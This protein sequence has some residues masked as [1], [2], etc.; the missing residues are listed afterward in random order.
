LTK[1]TLKLREL[2]QSD[3][4][5][6]APGVFNP[7]LAR[8]AERQG[9]SALYAGGSAISINVF[10]RPDL[11]LTSLSERVEAVYRMTEATQLPVIVDADIGFGDVL[12]LR[13]CVRQLERVGAAAIHI[14]DES[15][16]TSHEFGVTPATTA[17]MCKRI[18]IAAN[19][20]DDS[21]F[22]IFARC[23][24]LRT[25]GIHETVGRA[26]AYLDAGADG[27]FVL[28]MNPDEVAV[29]ARTFPGVTQIYNM[30]VR[31]D[32]PRMS[33]GEVSALGYKIIILPN[34]LN[35]GLM[36]RAQELLADVH[37]KGSI[38][39]LIEQVA[40]PEELELISGLNEAQEFQ[41]LNTVLND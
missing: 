35:L 27:L 18:E 34:L 14:E 29:F 11:G 17:Q 19:T 21:D 28:G 5:I 7:L 39:H 26:R 2:L 23:N 37:E 12:G 16:K 13:E 9:F 41:V 3:H 38:A 30:T 6:V 4:A 33:V 24:T 32:G 8:L 40:A 1:A 36:R 22:M 25:N 10:G 31:G 20:R 15:A